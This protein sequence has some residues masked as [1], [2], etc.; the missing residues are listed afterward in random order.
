MINPGPPIVWRLT[1]PQLLLLEWGP[2][3]LNLVLLIVLGVLQRR[4]SA[5]QQWLANPTWGR[6]KVI[7]I[8]EWSFRLSDT[9]TRI[10]LSWPGI[11][12]AHETANLLVL[13]AESGLRYL[14]PKRAFADEADL[15]RARSLI[16]T[17]VPDNKLQASPVG[18]AV[19]AAPAAPP[20]S[21]A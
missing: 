7:E 12:R 4:W 5:R 18:F 20:V 13:H 9:V 15:F 2:W 16:Q 6:P 14:I 10:E 11:V 19:M 3:A 8:D 17:A 1:R 21:P